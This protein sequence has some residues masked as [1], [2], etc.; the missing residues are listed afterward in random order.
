VTL[1]NPLASPVRRSVTTAIATPVSMV[2]ILF[3]SFAICA[4]ADNN[5]STASASIQPQPER[6]VDIL[7]KRCLNDPSQ[8]LTLRGE[9]R[10]PVRISSKYL[11][12]DARQAVW[13]HNP[14]YNI[15]TI[16]RI[17]LVEN[18][19]LCW[20]GGLIQG[21]TLSSLR[22]NDSTKPL[23][24]GATITTHTN[25]NVF[26]YGL[27]ARG[28]GHGLDIRE[29]RGSINLAIIWISG[30]YG[31]C[32]S[33]SS[34][35][36]LK[37]DG[38]LIED[39]G[40]LFAIKN[41]SENIAQKGTLN[42]TN[43]LFSETRWGNRDQTSITVDGVRI[44]LKNNVFYAS[45]PDDIT[46]SQI[47]GIAMEDIIECE[48]NVVIWPFVEDWPDISN[49]CI[50][51]TRNKGI[52]QEFRKNWIAGRNDRVENALDGTDTLSVSMPTVAVSPLSLMESQR[53]ETIGLDGEKSRAAEVEARAP[54]ASDRGLAG[55]EG[56]RGGGSG[57]WWSDGTGWVR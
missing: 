42:I 34:A 55:T 24:T 38:S 3:I 50:K 13:S 2:C 21:Q 10:R 35:G 7:P 45:S 36:S 27:Q 14:S 16:P 8:V 48:N 4:R 23:G 51:L 43:N 26:I 5:V 49:K 20:I 46:A 40:V 56:N 6:R 22:E 9:Y 11:M 29:N 32:I 57:P 19:Q 47:F 53:N 18:D 30:A 41:E 15:R 28:V 1:R 39:C 17:S 44:I 12:V 33:G 31:S 54:G 25:A 37:I 52:W